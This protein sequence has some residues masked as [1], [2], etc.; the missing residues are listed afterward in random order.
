[1]NSKYWNLSLTLIISLLIFL[2]FTLIQSLVLIIIKPENIDST[3]LAYE[4]LAYSNLGTISSISSLFG[5]AG[6]LIFIYIKKTSFSEYLNLYFPKIEIIIVFVFLS[7]IMMFLMEYLSRFFPVLF[8]TDFVVESYKQA[9]SLPIFYIGV[10]FFG[11]I[12]EEFLF[13]GFLFK[14]LENSF[15]L[16]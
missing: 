14:G 9:R 12:F 16:K 7:F 3:N 6:I 2:V 4:T 8:E 15:F 1:M 13:R 10:V 11:P 5:I